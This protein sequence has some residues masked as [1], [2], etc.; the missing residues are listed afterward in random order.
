MFVRATPLQ[1]IG[2]DRNTNLATH[3]YAVGDTVHFTPARSDRSS[4][5]AG[6]YRIIRLMPEDQGDQQYRIKSEN[7]THERTAGEGQLDKRVTDTLFKV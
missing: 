6:S 1:S 4:A 3:R 5:P 2:R 7:D